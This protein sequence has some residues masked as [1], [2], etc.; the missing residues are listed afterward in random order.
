MACV[1]PG[2]AGKIEGLKGFKDSVAIREGKFGRKGA[3]AGDEAAASAPKRAGK[4]EAAGAGPGSHEERWLGSM[5]ARSDARVDEEARGSG[6]TQKDDE[7]CGEGEVEEEDEACATGKVLLGKD[8]KEFRRDGLDGKRRRDHGFMKKVNHKKKDK[9]R[10]KPPC[11]EQPGS[12]RAAAG[13]DDQQENRDENRDD[14]AEKRVEGKGQIIIIKPQKKSVSCD[15]A[16]GDQPAEDGGEKEEDLQPGSPVVALASHEPDTLSA[17]GQAAEAQCETGTGGGRVKKRNGKQVLSLQEFHATSSVDLTPG[18]S[19]EEREH[20][21]RI[22]Q[23][24]KD[25]VCGPCCICLAE[26]VETSR[27]V[28]ALCALRATGQMHG[29]TLSNAGV[30]DNIARIANNVV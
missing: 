14:K 27:S 24:R 22:E 8:G 21:A 12:G 16:A 1:R 4:N 3:A 28:F 26:H 23:E 6:G 19:E 11:P 2:C 18:L 30:L 20:L 13:D 10:D 17:I 15:D 29:G 5:Q 9:D 25:E 7:A